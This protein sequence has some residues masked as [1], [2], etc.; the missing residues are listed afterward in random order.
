VYTR[1]AY[2]LRA[3]NKKNCK[4]RIHAHE[5]SDNLVTPWKINMILKGPCIPKENN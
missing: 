3:K 4:A 2:A 5:E 1:R